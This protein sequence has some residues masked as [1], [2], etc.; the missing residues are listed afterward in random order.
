MHRAGKGNP[1]GGCRGDEQTR[2]AIRGPPQCPPLPARA[3]ARGSPGADRRG[4]LA[5]TVGVQPAAPGL[6]HRHR[7]RPARRAGHRLATSGPHCRRP[8]GHRPGRA[9]DD[10]IRLLRRYETWAFVFPVKSDSQAILTLRFTDD[11]GL[12]WQVDDDLH[13]EQRAERDW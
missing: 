2:D 1:L 7:P 4:R 5:G 3:A 13:L 9:H 8:R 11:A 10:K 6:H 12:H